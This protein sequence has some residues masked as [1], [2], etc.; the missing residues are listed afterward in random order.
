M[1]AG[2]RDDTPAPVRP[3][4]PAPLAV[5][6]DLA[7]TRFTESLRVGDL[8]DAAGYSPHH[9]SRLFHAAF[10]L[11]PARYLTAVRLAAAKQVLLAGDDP[12]IDVAVAAGFD[13]LSSF[14]R[15]FHHDVGVRPGALRRLAD[16]VAEHPLRPFTLGSGAP[17]VRVRLT[18][19]PPGPRSRLTWIGWFPRPVP[20]GLP[21]AGV[22]AGGDEAALALCPGNPWLLAFTVPATVE[23]ADLLAPA[24]PTVAAHPRPVHGPAAITLTF[25][26][27]EGGAVPLL[28]ALPQLY[29]ARPD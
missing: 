8:A 16:R 9:F 2:P 28:P 21:R 15:R 11:S 22:L 1:S 14:S 7:R 3:A 23:P 27:A 18:G 6:A 19:R 4:P 25:G 29:W 17:A 24:A 26:P 12:V 10:G 13:S 5:A 20:V